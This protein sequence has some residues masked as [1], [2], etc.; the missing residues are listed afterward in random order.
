[1]AAEDAKI[2]GL[3]DGYILDNSHHI[4]KVG[5]LDHVCINKKYRNQGIAQ[6]LIEEFANKMKDKNVRYIKLNAFEKNFPAINLYKKLGF[7]EY[8][9]YYIKKLL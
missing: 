1:M 6:K 4:E 8:S 3:V 7:E 2:I 9:R 5:Y